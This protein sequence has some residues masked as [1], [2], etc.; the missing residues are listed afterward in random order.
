MPGFFRIKGYVIFKSNCNATKKTLAQHSETIIT[1]REKVNIYS[2]I[3]LSQFHKI[4]SFKKNL[5]KLVK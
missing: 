4:V 1:Q 2:I 3:S 5:S